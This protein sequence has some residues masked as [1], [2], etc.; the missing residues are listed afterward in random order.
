MVQT[1]VTH[2][3]SIISITATEFYVAMITL[4]RKSAAVQDKILPARGKWRREVTETKTAADEK[5][6]RSERKENRGSSGGEKEKEAAKKPKT[7]TPR[8]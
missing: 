3:I 7:K 1:F 8:L 6:K 2:T 5:N 4:E